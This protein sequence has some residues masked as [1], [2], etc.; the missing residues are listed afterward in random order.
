[1]GEAM[2]AGLEGAGVGMESV[3]VVE[4]NRARREELQGRYRGLRTAERATDEVVGAAEV[5]VAAVK[6]QMA[7]DA[8]RHLKVPPS[9][10][11]V[12]IMAGITISALSTLLSNHPAIVRAMPNTPAMVF[13]AVSVYTWLPGSI[14]PAQQALAESLMRAMGDCAIYVPDELYLD[15][16]GGISG[17]G[18]AY[19]FLLL[20]TFVDTA[21][22][23]GFARPQAT[24]MILQLFEGSVALAK[25]NPDKHLAVLR[26]QVTSPGGQT[27]AGL[28]A[29][30]RDGIRH[31]IRSGIMASYHRSLELGKAKL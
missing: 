23:L 12:S 14:S 30:E 9:A 18:P 2:V 22:E 1:M 11:V 19:V 29:M 21:V 24:Q 16:A 20:E 27:A 6:P 17:S 31:A 7:A 4:V 5:V 15:K 25:A 3:V 8:L 26:N 10:V 28:A 13:K